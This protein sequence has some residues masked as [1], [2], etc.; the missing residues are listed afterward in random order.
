MA[1]AIILLILMGIFDGIH[2]MWLVLNDLT[3]ELNPIMNWLLEIDPFLFVIAKLAVPIGGGFVLYHYRTC[4]LFN[5]IQVE[6]VTTVLVTVYAYITFRH[7]TI[8]F[9]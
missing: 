6:W 7:L 2:T 5:F 4:K 8:M 3:V 1:A 9:S